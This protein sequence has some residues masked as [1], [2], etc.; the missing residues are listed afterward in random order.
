MISASHIQPHSL[1]HESI[2]WLI[3]LS[4]DLLGAQIR[5]NAIFF[6]EKSRRGVRVTRVLRGGSSDKIAWS[7]MKAFS[8]HIYVFL[9]GETICTVDFCFAGPAKL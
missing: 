1:L 4:E 8:V 2:F 5:Q 7:S 6:L 3:I 9:W